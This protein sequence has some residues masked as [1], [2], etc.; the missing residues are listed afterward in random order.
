MMITKTKALNIC[1]EHSFPIA[2]NKLDLVLFIICSHQM[3]LFVWAIWWFFLKIGFGQMFFLW[4][5]LIVEGGK[6]AKT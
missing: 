3:Y 4:S 2:N 5:V 6:K 1:L